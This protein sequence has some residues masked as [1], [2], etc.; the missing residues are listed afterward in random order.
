MFW[1]HFLVEDAL[2]DGWKGWKGHK[3]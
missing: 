2:D 1:F 3:P